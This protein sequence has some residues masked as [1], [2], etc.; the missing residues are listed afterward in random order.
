MNIEATV[1]NPRAVT[2]LL[3]DPGTWVPGD[4][5]D[6]IEAPSRVAEVDKASTADHRVSFNEA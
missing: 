2:L 4:E 1:L 6:V 3:L 5:V